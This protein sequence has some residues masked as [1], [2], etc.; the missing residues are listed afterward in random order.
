MIRLAGLKFRES[1]AKLARMSTKSRKKFLCLDCG[2]DTARAG[3]LY[4]LVD[5][6]WKL[7]GLGKIGMLCVE[8]VEKRIGRKLIPADF[9]NSYLNK[10]RTRI[11]STRLMSRMVGDSN[12]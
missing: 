10:P 2:V 7:T 12:A 8:D 4:M 5:S 3:E 1:H 9:N 11:I 6:A